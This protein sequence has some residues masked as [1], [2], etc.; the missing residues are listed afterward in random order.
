MVC[1]AFFD[2]YLVKMYFLKLNNL[3]TQ[4]ID[5]KIHMEYNCFIDKRHKKATG[6]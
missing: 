5:D 2:I 1:C 6:T 3:E 4:C